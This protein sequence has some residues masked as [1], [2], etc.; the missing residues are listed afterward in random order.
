MVASPW[1][2]ATSATANPPGPCLNANRPGTP[3]RVF[4]AEKSTILSGS[5]RIACGDNMKDEPRGMIVS[6]LVGSAMAFRTGGAIA[7]G[8]GVS[9]PGLQ[10]IAPLC[11]RA[12]AASASTQAGEGDKSPATGITVAATPLQR[13]RLEPISIPLSLEGGETGLSRMSGGHSRR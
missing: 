2:L 7:F 6:G 4:I 1:M 3:N 5:P 9:H 12:V 11:H 13:F 8:A 10:Q